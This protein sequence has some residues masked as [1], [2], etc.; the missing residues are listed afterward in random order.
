MADIGNGNGNGVLKKWHIM[1]ALLAIIIPSAK[2]VFFA[3]DTSART[4][5]RLSNLSLEVSQIKQ[6]YA[7]KDVIDERLLSIEKSQQREEASEIELAKT[8]DDI[9]T[10]LRKHR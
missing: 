8:L 7:R 9:K 1:V 3:G 2:L 10:E 4:E 5:E 6:E